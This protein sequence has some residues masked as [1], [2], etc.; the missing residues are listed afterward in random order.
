MFHR[1]YTSEASKYGEEM[2]PSGRIWSEMELGLHS[3]D[4]L[5]E[6]KPDLNTVFFYQ[7]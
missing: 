5:T 4:F 6:E 2:K 7:N 1:I 3:A